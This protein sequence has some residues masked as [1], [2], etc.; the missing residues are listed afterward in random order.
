MLHIGVIF[1][2]GYGVL[3]K[4]AA[5]GIGQSFLSVR[6]VLLYGGGIL[7]LGVYA[8]LWQQVLK[9]VK[10]T[11][12]YYNKSIAILWGMILGRTIFGEQITWNMLLGSV[13][14]LVGIFLVVSGE[15]E[16]K[17]ETVDEAKGE[18]K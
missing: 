12:A 11:T 1:Y 10:L 16:G 15:G 3:S 7:L 2:S 8:I 5:E 9:R 13:V 18:A 17:G 6:F 4:F 14:V